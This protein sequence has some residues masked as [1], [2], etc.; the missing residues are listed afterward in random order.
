[1]VPRGFSPSA[2]PRQE[3]AS[4]RDGGVVVVVVVGGVEA[5]QVVESGGPR[6]VGSAVGRV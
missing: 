6:G 2:G 5:V 4:A 3:A 1:L